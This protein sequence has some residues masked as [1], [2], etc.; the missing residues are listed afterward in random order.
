MEGLIDAFRRRN[1][2]GGDLSVDVVTRLP[3]R[4]VGAHNDCVAPGFE[5]LTEHVSIHRMASGSAKEGMLPMCYGFMVYA[6]KVIWFVR[7][8]NYDLVFATSSRLMTAFLGC[9]CSLWLRK[10]LYLDIRDIFPETVGDVFGGLGKVL[11]PFVD[12]V[13]R[14]VVKR[15]VA[16][17][18]V[19][20]GFVEYYKAINDSLK[21]SI[22]TNG[23]D[24]CFV[25]IPADE[26]AVS[27]KSIL[28]VGNVGAGQ[29]LHLLLPHVYDFLKERG[30]VFD[31]VGGGAQLARLEESLEGMG[32]VFRL[33]QPVQR[34]EV[35]SLLMNADV[36][37]LHLNDLP[38]FEKVLP[39]KV[40]EYAASGKPIIAGVSGSSADFISS[41]IVNAKVFK[42]LS[43]S[44]FF[45]SFGAIDFN[46]HDR[47]A[48]I[49][50]YSRSAIMNR[51]VLDIEYVAYHS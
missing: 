21:I 25:N 49:E 15:A 51:M 39:S 10:P 14:L 41:E 5:R 36:L 43:I 4:Y 24:S 35:P 38:A 32:E 37:F 20:S 23:I 48:F 45:E 42:P 50:K 18:V 44:G 33:H 34:S 17:N 11:R 31:I 22:F 8:S 7:R 27:E 1:L 9:I 46:E 26:S 30:W 6:V 28:Y 12:W 16:M 3:H 47:S 29:G 40:F 2:G 19:S 13:E